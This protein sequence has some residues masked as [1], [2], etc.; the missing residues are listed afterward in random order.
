[1]TS[2]P[3]HSVLFVCLGNICRS[4]LAEGV[5]RSVLAAGRKGNG[6]LIDSAGTNGYHTG[7]LP[8]K[9][10]IV[11]ASRHG[12]DISAQRCRQLTADDFT[13][14]DLI[15]GMD[16]EN[17]AT[18]KARRPSLATA[19]VGMFYELGLGDSIQIPDPYYGTSVDFERVY[20]L[21]LEAS[22]GLSARF[23]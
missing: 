7:E 22:K 1:M 12:I 14:F 21:I 13:R 15:I 3:L 20:R 18:I 17:I 4:P 11:V 10:S 6:V 2:H 19:E 16:R 23:G 9:R 5:F 8:D